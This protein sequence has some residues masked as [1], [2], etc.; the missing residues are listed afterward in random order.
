MTDDIYLDAN[1]TTQVLPVAAAAALRVMEQNFGNPSSTHYRGLQ[2][3][4]LMSDVRGQ[5]QR[6]LG[7]GEGRMVFVSGATEAIQTAVLSALCD[8]R[9]RLQR[10]ESVGS[11]LVVGATEHKAVPESIIHWN[12]VLGLNLDLRALPVDD[13][14][15]HDLSALAGMVNDAALV[16]TMAANN[17]TGAISDLD[18]IARVLHGGTSVPLWLVDGVQALGKLPLALDRLRI[19]YAAFSGHKLYAPKGTGLLYVRAG[20]P[21]TPLMV[22]GGQENGNR[23]GTENLAGIAALGAVLQMLE[24]GGLFR[25]PAEMQHMRDRLVGSLRAA[26]PGVVFNTPF[27][28]AL[29]T[30]INFSVPGRTSKE[31]LDVF[32]AAGIRVSSGSACSA[33]KALPS[34]VLEAMGLPAWRA[35]SAIR[36]SF[37]PATQAAWITRACERIL[38]CGQAITQTEP[39]H[40]PADLAIPIDLQVRQVRA[41]GNNSWILPD[42]S[43]THCV[44]I[45]PHPETLPA[46]Q[47]ELGRLPHAVT[48]VLMTTETVRATQARQDLV[49]WLGHRSGIQAS[50]RVAQVSPGDTGAPATGKD[51]G[52]AVIPIGKESLVRVVHAG[53]TV[54][55][56][57]TPGPAGLA[58]DAVRLVFVA[59]SPRADG[60]DNLAR[61]L[62]EVAGHQTVICCAN[63]DGAALP[64][65]VMSLHETAPDTRAAGGTIAQQDIHQFLSDHPDARLV[66]LRE[67]VELL[68]GGPARMHSHTADCAA[69]SQFAN[70]LGPW[71][72]QREAPLVFVCRS[73]ARSERAASW[74]RR[75]GH[76]SAW[77]LGGGLALQ[78]AQAE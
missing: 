25:T 29:P 6:L 48:A 38:Q 15:Q 67:P 53:T 3:R 64:G 2:A 65:T 68:V 14:G 35:A 1:A 52:A 58:G 18:G 75:M 50:R 66:D 71:L 39:W 5:A 11:L 45:D 55:L 16:C 37:G 30:T 17:E 24:V 34:H 31:L 12:R 60:T 76:T 61:R 44:V 19:D 9:E 41:E 63:D 20:A 23:S 57:G 4:E 56:L 26:F 32:D 13:R 7:S 51:D 21:F 28:R 73:G 42:A 8:I 27:D 33:A 70:H 36:M 74:M 49:Q 62:T 22:G 54:Y 40:P 77:H 72:G 10:G 59:T 43:G 46:L 69:L 47:R 78:T